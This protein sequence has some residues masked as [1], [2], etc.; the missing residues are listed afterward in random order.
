MIKIVLHIVFTHDFVLFINILTKL[1]QVII[2]ILLQFNKHLLYH[3]N[4]NIYSTVSIYSNV[5]DNVDDSVEDS[6]DTVNLFLTL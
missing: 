3:Y 2:Y 5:D 6:V 4:V 1:N